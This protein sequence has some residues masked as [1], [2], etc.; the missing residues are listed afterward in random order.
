MKLVID[1]L[2]QSTGRRE[3]AKIISSALIQI[4]CT[5]MLRSL[6]FKYISL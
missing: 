3:L 4:N 5:L 1:Q 6:I 2:G